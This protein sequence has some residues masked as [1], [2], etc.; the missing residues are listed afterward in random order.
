MSRP[1]GARAGSPRGDCDSITFG[2]AS[3]SK[4]ALPRC[5]SI[6]GLRRPRTS[7]SQ[8]LIGGDQRPGWWQKVNRVPRCGRQAL[9]TQERTPWDSSAEL[10][11]RKRSTGSVRNTTSLRVR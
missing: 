2:S 8:F 5:T 3:M 10:S 11:C 1:A 6:D 4:A 9:A 7:M